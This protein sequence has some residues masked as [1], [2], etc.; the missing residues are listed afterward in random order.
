MKL[1]FSIDPVPASRPRVTR[2]AT[3]Y[4]KPYTNFKEKMEK[5][6]EK[7]PKTLIN[8]PL[9]AEITFY[10]Q[11]APSSSKKRKE[12][13]D[14]KFCVSN[15][16]LDNLEKAIYDAL[17]EHVYLDDKQVVRHTTQKI[18]VKDNP[19]IEIE[20]TKAPYENIGIA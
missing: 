20:F 12:L 4:S 8:C 10:I 7:V 17:N 18:W 16:D 6:L 14:G 1:V 5:L 9:F 13:L 2:W 11:I 15:M 19:R 3:Y